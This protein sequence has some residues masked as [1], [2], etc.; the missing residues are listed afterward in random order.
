MPIAEFAAAIRLGSGGVGM[1]MDEVE[2]MVA[3]CIYKVSH[4][5]RA[6]DQTL[7]QLLVASSVEALLPA[8]VAGCLTSMGAAACY[9]WHHSRP[10]AQSHRHVN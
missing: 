1:D 4:A 2:C 5:S 3:N 10:S 7:L 6:V 9:G 8:E